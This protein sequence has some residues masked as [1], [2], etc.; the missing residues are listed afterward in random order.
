[1]PDLDPELVNTGP[2]DYIYC[3]MLL[4][5]QWI[6]LSVFYVQ[7]VFWTVLFNKIF[8]N[9]FVLKQT[10]TF[11][12][13]IFCF[14]TGFEYYDMYC[15]FGN[16]FYICINHSKKDSKVPTCSVTRSLYNTV[17]TIYRT[18]TYLY[19]HKAAQ[20]WISCQTCVKAKR[21]ARTFPGS[22]S[23]RFPNFAMPDG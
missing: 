4:Y 15:R 22:Q 13:D 9:C 1:M 16:R 19:K 5:G 23:I 18:V 2:G 3:I 10:Y 14:S 12:T 20:R 7:P 21:A 11:V 6:C 17:T 8:D